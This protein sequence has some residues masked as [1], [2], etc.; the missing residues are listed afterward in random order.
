SAGAP[1]GTV[2]TMA[3][4]AA[5]SA[6]CAPR[7]CATGKRSSLSAGP[8]R[9]SPVSG[10]FLFNSLSLNSFPQETNP[11]LQPAMAL[12]EECQEGRGVDLFLELGA[13]LGF[14]YVVEADAR[15]QTVALKIEL[16]FHRHIQ[17]EE[18]GKPELAGAGDD[19]AELVYRKEWE[20]GVPD[21]GVGQI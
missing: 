2:P 1:D 15:S 10:D 19:A 4:A 9:L 21:C 20:A 5:A 6:A 11:A 14:S 12:S 3:E 16:A 13:F 18:V 7:A 8:P 17:S